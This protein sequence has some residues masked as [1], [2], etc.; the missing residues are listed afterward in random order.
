MGLYAHP[1][2]FYGECAQGT[3]I[4][5]GN[6]ITMDDKGAPLVSERGKVT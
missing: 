6:M 4:H 2:F 5:T 1:A 3:R